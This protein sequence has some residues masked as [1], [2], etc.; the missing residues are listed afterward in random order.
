M[1]V[2]ARVKRNSVRGL[3]MSLVGVLVLLSVISPDADRVACADDA[4]EVRGAARRILSAREFRYVKSLQRKRGAPKYDRP[5]NG[6]PGNGSGS[7]RTGRSQPGSRN[8]EERGAG[9]ENGE[10]PDGQHGDNG[11][12]ENDEFENDEGR[13]GEPGDDWRP[14]GEAGGDGRGDDSAFPEDRPDDPMDAETRQQSSAASEAIGG[15]FGIIGWLFVAVIVTLMIVMAV[16]GLMEF[17]SRDRPISKTDDE[18]DTT[19]EGELEPETAPGELPAD[20]YITKAREFAAA[21]KYREAVAQL[22]L[23]AMSNIERAGLI[24]YRK[25]LTH[26]DYARAVRSDAKI[27]KSMKAMVRVYE[28]L[29]FGRRVA[30]QQHFEQT[31]SGYQAG[32]RGTRSTQ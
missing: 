15:F 12:F 16:K 22:L 8:G 23:G 17:R 31:L 29:G 1:T 27:F 9:N 25:G 30:S 26:R 19:A 10:G 4:P 11:E 2:A 24:R 21:G 14:G 5:G 7:G 28:P 20:V 32:F 13:F 18:P 6:Q 3:V